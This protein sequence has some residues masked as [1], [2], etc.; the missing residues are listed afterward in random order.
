MD[1]SWMYK[2]KDSKLFNNDEVEKAQ[3]DGWFDNR[4]DANR[5]K[6]PVKKA[7]PVVEP[8]KETKPGNI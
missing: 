6:E 2:G 7:A 8:K 1:Q 5:Q 3:A 4:T